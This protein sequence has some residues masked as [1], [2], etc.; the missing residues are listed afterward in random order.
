[1]GQCAAL[2]CRV[3]TA[4][5]SCERHVICWRSPNVSPPA[6]TP[7]TGPSVSPCTVR[8]STG[9]SYPAARRVRARVQ[10]AS[11]PSGSVTS[12]ISTSYGNS[13]VSASPSC[14][15]AVWSTGGGHGTGVLLW[16]ALIAMNIIGGGYLG[17]RSR[18]PGGFGATPARVWLPEV[19]TETSFAVFGWYIGLQFDLQAVR[20]MDRFTPELIGFVLVMTAVSAVLGLILA[21]VIGVDLMTGCLATTPG[22][23]NAVTVTSMSA[24]TN[25]TLVVLV[26]TVRLL[27]TLLLGPPLVGWWT[28]RMSTSAPQTA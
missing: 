21:R 5:Q 13:R 8:N 26:Q 15:V 17:V 22:G 10:P 9:A 27:A 25:T 16:D 23:I 7:D 19:A 18:F 28:R 14:A 1:M 4:D 20:T 3:S 6:S 12:R 11:A 2:Y 24:G